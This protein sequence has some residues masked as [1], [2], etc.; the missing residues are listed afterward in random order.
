MMIVTAIIM[1]MI[2]ATIVSEKDSPNTIMPTITAVTGSIA[3]NTEVWVAP[4]FFM[5]SIKARLEITVGIM[6]NI[7]RLVPLEKSEII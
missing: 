3:P 1:S 5:A 7:R 6:A 2:P 4:M